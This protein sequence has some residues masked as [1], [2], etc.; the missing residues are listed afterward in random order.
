M[1][2]E[3]RCGLFSH[4][5]PPARSSGYPTDLSVTDSAAQPITSISL[6]Y[7]DATLRTVHC[8]AGLHKSLEQKFISKEGKNVKNILVGAGIDIPR[9]CSL[10]RLSQLT[11]SKW[12]VRLAAESFIARAAR[13]SWYCLQFIPSWMACEEKG[14]DMNDMTCKAFRFL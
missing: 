8:L 12:V 3:G 4:P 7:D 1:T 9:L 2:R 5:R 13:S 14:W 6:L 11:F 10:L